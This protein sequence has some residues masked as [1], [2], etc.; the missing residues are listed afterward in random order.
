MT[1][2]VERQVEV[3]HDLGKPEALRVVD[4]VVRVWRLVRVRNVPDTRETCGRG[5]E[6]LEALDRGRRAVEV[7]RVTGHT[8]RVE[9]TFQDFGT[10]KVVGRAGL[11]EEAVLIIEGQVVCGD[12]LV[13][14]VA[15][16]REVSERLGANASAERVI[17]VK[18]RRVTA[19]VYT[20]AVLA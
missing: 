1:R 15:L 4:E 8:P 13:G 6:L 9:V 2:V 19:S 7:L 17:S 5:Q 16:V 18:A 14:D 20:H 3:L 10:L 12:L 11:D